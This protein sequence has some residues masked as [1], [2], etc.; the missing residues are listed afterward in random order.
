[1][2]GPINTHSSW[3]I[4]QEFSSQ[5]D[6]RPEDEARPRQWALP[7]AP[8]SSCSVT[9]ENVHVLSVTLIFGLKR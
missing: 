4:W 8:F 9:W 2:F 7:F 3:T 5:N 6:F 1:M